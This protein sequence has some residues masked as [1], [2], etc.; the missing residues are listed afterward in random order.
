MQ[1]HTVY[2]CDYCGATFPGVTPCGKH[3]AECKTKLDNLHLRKS[4]RCSN[5]RKEGNPS[6]PFIHGSGRYMPGE[7]S[8]CD[9][10][11]A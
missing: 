11:E 8:V 1:S 6:C 4:D 9:A 7:S 3:E 5:C 2:V 10:Y